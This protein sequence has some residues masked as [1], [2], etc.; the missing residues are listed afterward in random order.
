M[1]ESKP[2]YQSL[3]IWGG[4]VL[5]FLVVV[6]PLFGKADVAA[7]VEASKTDIMSILAKIGE[8]I[9]L[10]A[11]VYGRIRATAVVTPKA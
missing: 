10:A 11:V 2:W 5:G 4:I 1:T 9:A 8:V 7:N 6:L 3:T